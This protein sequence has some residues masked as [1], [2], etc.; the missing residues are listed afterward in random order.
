MVSRRRF[1]SSVA[2]AVAAVPSARLDVFSR[3]SV[4][5]A[6][7][8]RFGPRPI[9]SLRWRGDS[10]FSMGLTQGTIGGRD[11]S[12][13]SGAERTEDVA[14]PRVDLRRLGAQLRARY[15]DLAQHFLFEYYP[16]YGTN[17]WFHWDHWDRVLPA[18][19]AAPSMPR[20]GPYDSRDPAVIE[21]HA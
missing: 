11:P 7:R 9:P 5:A 3:P 10:A 2:A 17:P 8:T 18:G 14:V 13:A 21:Q 16:W 20:L 6:L 19:I 1:L 15:A 12:R 4:N